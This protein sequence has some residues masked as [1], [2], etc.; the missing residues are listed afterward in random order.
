MAALPRSP[1]GF[2]NDSLRDEREGSFMDCWLLQRPLGQGCSARVHVV[3]GLG[4]RLGI[5]AACKNAKHSGKVHWQRIVRTFER[6]A[7]LL[8][9]CRHPNIVECLGF[10]SL[11]P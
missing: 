4:G 11:Q 2:T 7:E 3:R 6:E 9:R 1:E 5:E 10:F 8:R